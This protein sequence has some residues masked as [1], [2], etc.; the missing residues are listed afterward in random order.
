MLC[1]VFALRRKVFVKRFVDISVSSA[2]VLGFRASNSMSHLGLSQQ[3]QIRFVAHIAYKPINE[4]FVRFCRHHTLEKFKWFWHL[5]C[6]RCGL[7]GML[8]KWYTGMI[9]TCILSFAQG[10]ILISQVQRLTYRGIWCASPG[11]CQHLLNY[12]YHI[13]YFCTTC[14]YI[15][16]HMLP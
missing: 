13:S 9:E 1:F 8:Q 3:G 7:P 11:L 10:L 2:K 16:S 12:A 6:L 4:H 15:Q 14:L 5:N